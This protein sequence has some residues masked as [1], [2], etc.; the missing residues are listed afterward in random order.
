M[1]IRAAVHIPYR[2]ELVFET[3]RD[4]AIE[5]LPYLPNIRSLKVRSRRESG[6]LVELVNDWHGGGDVPAALRAVLSD[7]VL[8]WT[9]YATWDSVSFLCDWKTEATLLMDC[10]HCAGRNTFRSTGPD[11]TLL[12]VEGK[13]S[14]DATKLRGVPG[15]FAA[16]VGR[17]LEGFLVE[18]IRANLL[19]TAEG[20]KG[21][22]DRRPNGPP[23]VTEGSRS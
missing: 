2:R 3:Y 1:E 23:V 10:M 22:L 16:R 20:V 5:L 6:N 12:E 11:A 17:A 19:Q 8:T 15:F 4:D 21:H 7:S 13:L 9:D 18:R 14:I